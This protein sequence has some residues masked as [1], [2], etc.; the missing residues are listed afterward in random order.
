MPLMETIVQCPLS[1]NKLKSNFAPTTL[2]FSP[3]KVSARLVCD[4]QMNLNSCRFK[5]TSLLI[6]LIY[7]Q[8]LKDKVTN[9]SIEIANQSV[10]NFKTVE[11]SRCKVLFND[12]TAASSVINQ[13]PKTVEQRPPKLSE[14][15]RAISATPSPPI[16]SYTNNNHT[17]IP[18]VNIS[19]V[20][21]VFC[22]IRSR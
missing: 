10:N 5:I 9:P 18:I 17:P 13:K 19:Q 8:R 6:T 12:N 1:H 14:R 15:L 7:S 21:I 20:K 2:P 16:E 11:N 3:I 4:F 22:I